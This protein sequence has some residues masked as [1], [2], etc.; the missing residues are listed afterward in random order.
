LL[1]F[2]LLKLDRFLI[3]V[4]VR[5]ASKCSSFFCPVVCF[6]QEGGGP[7]RYFLYHARHAIVQAMSNAYYI[8][9]RIGF[10]LEWG[11]Y[12]IRLLRNNTTL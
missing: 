4:V 12:S 5:L 9:K 3:Q 10:F 11:E 7:P 2:L 6:L 1:Q 8:S